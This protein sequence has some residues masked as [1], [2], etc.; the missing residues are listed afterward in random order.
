MLLDERGRS[1]AADGE[2]VVESALEPERFPH[3]AELVLAQHIL[4]RGLRN[5]GNGRTI[6]ESGEPRPSV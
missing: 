2:P 6:N 4:G 3:C 5:G 1:W